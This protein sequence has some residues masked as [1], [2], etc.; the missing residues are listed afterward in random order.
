[1]RKNNKNKDGSISK[2][3]GVKEEKKAKKNEKLD[4]IKNKYIGAI[5]NPVKEGLSDT[6]LKII[7]C[8]LSMLKKEAIK[9]KDKVIML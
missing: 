6:T 7:K 2:N 8:T 9:G 3:S 5:I 1:M 4:R